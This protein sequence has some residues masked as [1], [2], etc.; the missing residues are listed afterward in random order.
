ML[1]EESRSFPS[2]LCSFLHSPVNLSLLGPNILLSTLPSNTLTHTL[3]SMWATKFHTHTQQQAKLWFC[4]SQSFYFWIAN[5]QTTKDSALN[6]SKHSLTKSALNFFLNRILNCQG[7][8]QLSKL[9]PPF[10]RNCYQSLCCDFIL[11]SNLE[12]WPCN[13]YQHLLLAHSS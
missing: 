8:S 4:I 7:C 9:F 13:C 3:P 11:H 6:D 1:G 10:Q 5:W 12:T 2:S